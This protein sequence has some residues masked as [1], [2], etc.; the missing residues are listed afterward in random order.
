MNNQEKMPKS[1]RIHE[2]AYHGNLAVF[3]IFIEDPRLCV[4]TSQLVCP[5]QIRYALIS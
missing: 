4:P 3:S 1:I 2:Q 5:F